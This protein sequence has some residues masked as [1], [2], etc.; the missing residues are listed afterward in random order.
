MSSI[1]AL[2][3][4]AACRA[5]DP[6]SDPG[7]ATVDGPMDAG[8]GDDDDGD[9]DDVVDSPATGD[10]G[11]SLPTPTADLCPALPP[12]ITDCALP[13]VVCVGDGGEVATLAGAADALAPGVTVVV[14]AGSYAGIRITTS[15][16]AS[17]PIT[18]IADGDAVIDAPSPT[19]DGFYLSDASYVRIEGFRI[20][21]PDGRCIAARDATPTRPV[22]GL[23]IVGNVCEGSGT[24]GFYLSEVSQSLVQ[25]NVITG[26]GRSGDIRSHGI[27]L[28]NAGS[29]DTTLAC[30]VIS[31]AGPAESNGIHVNGDRSV[32]GDGIVSGLAA[33]GNV[34]YGNRQNGFNLDGVQDSRF[35]GNVV[36]GNGL[37]ALRAYRIDGAQGPHNL[38]AVA[39]TLVAADGAAFKT[40]E[41]GGG[42]VVFDNVLASL[43]DQEGAISIDSPDTFQSA[44]NA[45]VGR[46]SANDQRTFLTL[47]EWQ[48][49]GFDAGSVAADLA[50][51]VT[52]A[53]GGDFTLPAGSPAIDLGLAAF[54]G[55]DAPT[56]DVAGV[57]RPQGDRID[58]GAYE[59]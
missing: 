33:I 41:D 12:P 27:Y 11:A 40:S 13:E 50:E 47:A 36:Y 14:S 58:A 51:L 20:V 7:G 17:A 3:V 4:L 45:L 55:V 8:P 23:Q 54:T 42:H 28:A 1:A 30:N 18:L 24:E 49:L 10:T 6:S 43:D 21:Q 38:V 53:A 29:D 2:W 56:V 16:T 19:G 35:I 37:H 15:G 59:R 9:D 39:N 34:I 22:F 52:D 44:A 26:S 5:P 46:L 31:G 32:G 57:A 25:G 48:A